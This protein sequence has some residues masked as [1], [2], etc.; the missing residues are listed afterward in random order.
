M[1][2]FAAATSWAFTVAGCDGSGNCYVRAGA[3]GSKNGSDWTNAYTDLP[4][5]LTR[6]ATYYVAAGTYAPHVFND[7]VSGTTLI[8]LLAP[9]TTT[10]GTSTGWNSSY[11]G[12][13]QWV[14]SSACG[15]VWNVGNENYVVFNG[16]YCT[17]NPYY[18]NICT[19]G[20]A[21][22]AIV[23]NGHCGNG[24]V[25]NGCTQ[26]GDVMGG[27]G[28]NGSPTTSHDQTFE[29]I[30]IDGNHQT[31]D[32]GLADAAFDFEGGSYNLYFGHLYLQY[33]TWDFFLKGNHQG[34]SG[35]GSG[36]DITIEYTF[37]TRDYTDRG[38]GTGPHGTPC[39][40]SEGL[41]NF[42]W[43]YNIITN[44]VG[45]NFGVDTASGGDYN[46]GNGNGGPWYQ[47]GNLWYA[48]DS[49][50]CAVGDGV[51]A[52]YDFSM[53]N[54]DVYFVNNSIVNEGYPFCSATDETGF[55]FGLT[56][57]TP[58][59][60]FYEENNLWYGDDLSAVNNNTILQNGT[61]RNGQGA[62]FSPAVVH[63][64]DA[65]FSSPNSGAND[66]DTHK[67]VSSSNPF[68]NSASTNYL[69]ASD[70][71]PGTTLSNVG[72]YWNGSAE[73]ANTFNVDMNGVVRGA[74]GTWDRGALQ[75]G[76][77]GLNPPTG[78]TATVH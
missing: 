7:A 46:T 9:T 44:M 19:Q 68:V 28:Y 55:G 61:T 27:I 69:L 15:P 64:Y 33:S 48:D 18:P 22:F 59:H 16:S 49:S 57:T 47:Y 74:N 72:T 75:I 24:N 42:T 10:H 66:A 17:P 51:M 34:Q 8:T 5:S 65:W 77:S 11:V 54:G 25:G 23:C 3:T 70:T 78:L 76:G 32:S 56:Y 20:T 29:Y 58:F 40:C 50:H 37:M 36:N 52:V 71:A 43:R 1:F 31:S 63:G 73:V 39:S 2:C 6:G 53:T 13:A 4:A 41:T 67:Q 12:Q 14:C 60:G 26:C 35:F 45:T 21:G 30:E 62:T 38:S